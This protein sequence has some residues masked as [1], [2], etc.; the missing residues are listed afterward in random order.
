MAYSY[1]FNVPESIP[2]DI[3][4]NKGWKIGE[5]I[6]L[7]LSLF[8]EPDESAYETES[9]E[10][11]LEQALIAVI[12]AY[13]NVGGALKSLTQQAQALLLDHSEYRIVDHPYDSQ[14]CA[15]IEKAVNYKK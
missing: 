8:N 3:L 14:T 7:P 11:A 15:E 10:T 4:K 1:Y 6:E 9:R 5:R 13:R 12:G 2:Q